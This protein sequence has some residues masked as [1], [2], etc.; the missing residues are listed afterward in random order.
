[1]TDPDGLPAEVRGAQQALGTGRSRVPPQGPSPITVSVPVGPGV[2][3]LFEDILSADKV[4]ILGIMPW[5]CAARLIDIS[6]RR[7]HANQPVIKAKDVRYFTPARDHIAVDQHSDVLG[8]LVQRW[9]AGI[10]GIRNWLIPRREDRA[11][12]QPVIY[13]F[14]EPYFGCVVHTV[15]DGRHT[16]TVFSQLPRITTR[17]SGD[18]VPDTTLLY[19]HMPDDQVQL[20]RRYLDGRARQAVPL[21][22]R[23][24]I[25]RR[26]E[27]TPG[28]VRTGT[29]F[30][31]YISHLIPYE[32]AL[33]ADSVTPVAVVAVCAPTAQGD[34]VLLKQRA[35]WNARDDFDSLSL[36]SERIR[37]VDIVPG[38]RRPLDRDDSRAVEDLWLQAGK[39]ED[40]VIGD[41]AFLRAAQ[42]ELYMSCGLDVETSR[43]SFR[44]SCL[45]NREGESTYLGFYVYRI[46]LAR[47]AEF[48]ELAHAEAWNPDLRRI[49]LKDLYRA[50]YRDRLNRL[51]SRREA[52]LQQA[53]FAA[54]PTEDGSLPPAGGTGGMTQ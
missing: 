1:M 25:C 54:P 34:A 21:V 28:S 18:E 22:S 13:E 36:V 39:P 3:Q 46:D 8:S 48:D 49:L 6:A 14:N 2:D 5:Q 11:T 37:E 24:L 52:W 51:L 35:R 30:T 45:L 12:R 16:G 53:V 29:E 20:F 17:I 41:G 23:D 10:T 9:V 19:S 42:R 33:P 27:S 50:G 44:G 4:D 47:S 26:V 31:P 43:L 32:R 15:R 40:F 38:L 7:Q